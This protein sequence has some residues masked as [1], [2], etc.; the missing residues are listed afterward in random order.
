MPLGYIPASGTPVAGSAPAPASGRAFRLAIVAALGGFLFGYDISIISGAVIFLER[1]F[2]LTEWQK[3]LAVSSAAIGCV[4]GP[5]VAVA[6]SDLIGRKKT[7]VIAAVLLALSA[8][9]TALPRSLTEFYLGRL[10]GGIGVGL[11]SIIC[12]MYIA[13]MSPPRLRG[14]LV[15]VNQLALVTGLFM[16]VVVS[17]GLAFGGHWRWMFASG[18]VPALGWLAALTILPESPRWL[19]VKRREEEALR[20]LAHTQGASE[21]QRALAEIKDSIAEE[22]GG[23]SEVF[24]PGMRLALLVAVV[25]AVLQ[26]MTGVSILLVYAPTVFQKAGFTATDAIWQAVP[27]NIW[28]IVCTGVAFWLVDRL[29]RKPLLMAGSALMALGLLLM[30]LCFHFGWSGYWVVAVMFLC[31]GAYVSSLAPLAWLVMS[32]IFLTRVR[33]KAMSVAGVALWLSFFAGSQ[34]FPVLTS[35]FTLH[36]G[37][38]AIVFWIFSAVCVFSFAFC[39]QVVPET[40]GRTLEEVAASWNHAR[41]RH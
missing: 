34:F 4:F 21:A 2:R 18:L 26:Q 15:S 27:L 13:E 11:A 38:P 17:Y 36:H 33:G 40:K 24:Q 5:L 37:S 19:V 3:G 10:V 12:P 30:G 6:A 23:W 31:V 29:G 35:Y 28:N 20:F 32:E 1:E 8:L 9:G 41:A 39:W 16:A 22:S 7:L 14:R 25:L